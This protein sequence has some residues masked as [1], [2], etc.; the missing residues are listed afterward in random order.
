VAYE[1]AKVAW[2]YAQFNMP[3]RTEIEYC[4]GGH[5][6]N[7]EGT[8]QFLEQHLSSNPPRP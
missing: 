5:A 1:Y 6:I 4:N 3:Q 2:L 7:G 8:F